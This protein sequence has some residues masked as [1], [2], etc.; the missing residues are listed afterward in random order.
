MTMDKLL[1]AAL[2][3]VLIGIV[4]FGYGLWAHSRTWAA[5]DWPTVDGVV[6]KSTVESTYSTRKGKSRSRY[7]AKVTYEYKI[8]EEKFVSNRV[9]LVEGEKTGSRKRGLSSRLGLTST[10]KTSAKNVIRRYPKGKTVKVFYNPASPDVAALEIK[11]PVL[12]D[13]GLWMGIP[14]AIIGLLAFFW[15]KKNMIQTEPE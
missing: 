3:V 4:G 12:V 9:N 2:F 15:V 6:I 7:Y 13:L 14:L 5:R 10:S 1:P 11:M 8:N